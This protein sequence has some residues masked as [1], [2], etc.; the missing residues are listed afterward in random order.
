MGLR[1][2]AAAMILW[3]PFFV[4]AAQRDY[5]LPAASMLLSALLCIAAGIL[6][7]LLCGRSPGLGQAVLFTFLV[8]LFFDIQFDWFEDAVIYVA[9]VLMLA[10]FWVLRR[11]IATILIAM[12]G[13][14]LLATVVTGPTQPYQE[15][16]LTENAVGGPPAASGLLIHLML[17]EHTGVMGIPEDLPGGE[18]AARA[19]RAFFRD[20]GFRLFG[21]AVS[22]YEATR[23]SVSGILNFTAGPTPY[24]RYIGKR[25]YVLRQNRYF[26]ALLEAGYAVH[27][28]QVTYMDYCREFPK[29]VSRCYTYLHDG[30]NWMKTAAFDDADK[31]SAFFSLYLQLSD[32]LVE[33]ALKLYVRAAQALRR[34]GVTLPELPKWDDGPGSI[35]A[36][37]AFDRLIDDVVSAPE[38][39]AFYAHFL[40]PHGPYIFR[41]DC[42]LRDNF[43]EWLS[44]RPPFRR[45]NDRAERQAS[46]M[47]YFD[48]LQCVQKKLDTLF[49]RLKEAGRFDDA[50]IIIHGDHGSR[51]HSVA[52]RAK[53]AD[54]LERNDLLAGFSTLF[55]VKGPGIEPG[56][57]ATSQPVSRLLPRVI[58]RPEL[59]AEPDAPIYFYLEGADDYD[60]WTPLLWPSGGESLSG[61]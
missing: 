40:L 9:C 34:H 1:A 53:N 5:P 55:A 19:Q 17:D 50:T 56:F 43:N 12:F 51:I 35:N 42:S 54:R 46:Y 32:E 49:G 38:G 25:P 36:A 58:G 33:D 61:G 6:L 10:L 26:D 24:D 39:T 18:A 23:N 13:A 16:W 8:A 4:F 3:V 21:N 59:A 47:A 20:N 45:E 29:L 48:Q 28:Y 14:L 30:T 44:N 52:A 31:L 37:A 11:H 57:D 22:E 60:P 27:V 41:P 15:S 2:L 7:S